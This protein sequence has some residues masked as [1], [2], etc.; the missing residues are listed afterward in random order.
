MWLGRNKKK[1]NTAPSPDDEAVMLRVQQGE[2]DALAILFDRYHRLVLSVALRILR[3][4]G[5]AED[6]VQNIFL[7]IFKSA[8]QFDP[9]RGTFLVWLMQHAYHRSIS[10]KNYLQARQFYTNAVLDELTEFDHGA[11]HF[12]TLPPQECMRFVREALALLSDRQ[13]STVEMVHFEGLTLK[14]IAERTE[15][16]YNNVRHHYY[17]GLTAL[18]HHLRSIREDMGSVK[19][20]P[21]L[22]VDRA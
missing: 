18:K 3:D 2:G 17:R 12:Y 13:R 21:G 7:E 1:E 4:Q 5:E 11:M 22:E 6:I 15:E 16:P 10:R 9:A 20:D 19:A 8:G 14:D